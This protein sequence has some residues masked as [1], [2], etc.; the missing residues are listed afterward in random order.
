MTKEA[1][2]QIADKTEHLSA[3]RQVNVIEMLQRNQNRFED[4]A[5]LDVEVLKAVLD[6]MTDSSIH[7]FKEGLSRAFHYNQITNELTSFKTATEIPKYNQIITTRD[8]RLFLIGRERAFEFN[9]MD[10]SLHDRAALIQPRKNT[11]I[12]Y[13]PT[14]NIIY[15]MGGNSLSTGMLD[16]CE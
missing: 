7:W 1:I 2:K 14:R 11:A 9:M 15:A 4:V 10:S 8:K 13:E 6:H 12:A 5:N 3:Q 16:T